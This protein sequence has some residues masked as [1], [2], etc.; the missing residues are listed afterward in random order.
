MVTDRGANGL[1]ASRRTFPVPEFT[2]VI[3]KVKAE[4]GTINILESIPIKTTAGVGVSGLP[5]FLPNDTPE[6]DEQAWDCAATTKIPPKQSGLD[7]EDLVRTH[8]GTFWLVEEYRPSI[9]KVAPDGN[10]LTRFVPFD[11]NPLQSLSSAGYP[12]SHSLPRI[13]GDKRKR[14]R[15]FEGLA[16]SPNQKT[17]FVALQ[18]PLQNPD[19]ATGNVSR[20]T[21]ILVFDI[22][23]EQPVAEFVYR[24]DVPTVATYGTTDPSE[25]KISALVALDPFRLLVEERTDAVARLY[26]VD[27]RQAT[28]ILGSPFDN[29]ATTALDPNLESESGFAASGVKALAKDLVVDLSTI[30]GVPPKIE[31]VAVL[32]DGHTIAI[33]ND[34]DFGVGTFTT[35][36]GCT[37]NDTG[38]KSQILIIKTDKPLK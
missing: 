25:M 10:I 13:Y 8:D 38:Q 7:T 16:I 30:A 24:F 18:S 35:T 11:P 5:N 37:L 15:G 23:T 32:D 6:S 34:N 20:N 9:L 2:P 28:D 31:G 27:V 29:P 19:A 12:I 4:N 33:S 26:R 1:I 22:Q 14:N 17:L 3:L 21:R 36:G